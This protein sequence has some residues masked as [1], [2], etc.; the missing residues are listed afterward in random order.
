MYMNVLVL[1]GSARPNSAASKVTP[2]VAQA[3]EARGSVADVVEVAT[4]NLPFFNAPVPPSHPDFA[5]TDANVIAWTDKV[6]AADAVVLL[7]PEYNGGPSAVQ[8][9]AIDWVYSPWEGKPV[10]MVGYGWYQPSRAQDSLKAAFGVVKAKQGKHV[11]LQFGVE[12]EADGS[13]KDTAAVEQKLMTALDSI[14]Q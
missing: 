6:A 8:K 11:Q 2:V 5:P 1:T 13:V 10:V 12:L 4:L 9:N 14:L 7:T 3:I